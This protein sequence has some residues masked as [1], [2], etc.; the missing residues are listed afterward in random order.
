MI[1]IC[2]KCGRTLSAKEFFPKADGLYGV[3]SICKICEKK[4][5]RDS[6]K[7]QKC[8]DRLSE[9]AIKQEQI[10][11]NILFKHCNKCDRDLPL[12]GFYNKKMGKY[13][14]ENHCKECKDKYNR[15]H[16][17]QIKQIDINKKKD[18]K[19][20]NYYVGL[21][22]YGKDN[23]F[24]GKHHT[25]E[26]NE[27]NRQWHLGKKASEETKQR[28]SETHKKSSVWIGRNHTEESKKKQSEVKLAEKNPVWKGGASFE[29]YPIGWRKKFKLKIKERD[30]NTCQLCYGNI[31]EMCVGWATHHIDYDKNNLDE[32]NLILLCKRCHGK[33]NHNH[34]GEWIRI[35]TEKMEARGLTKVNK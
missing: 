4:R 1:K 19:I 8:K 33:T 32:S 18:W 21:P 5:H 17:K 10:K 3:M 20:R 29:P 23:L 22:R 35:F 7:T 28:M 15:N 31:D 11:S 6:Y 34:R 24:Y 26:S 27:K 16:K 30:N 2:N 13:G 12:S 9:W 14:V 25:E